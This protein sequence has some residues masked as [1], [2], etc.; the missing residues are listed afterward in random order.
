MD[1][2]CSFF[3]HVR[4]R[5][6]RSMTSFFC[7]M[8]GSGLSDLWSV[9]ISV[10]L[11]CVPFKGKKIRWP[12]LS[13]FRSCPVFR[14]Y[15]LPPP[16][17]CIFWPFLSCFT[18]SC[19]VS[20]RISVRLFCVP[21]KGKK[22]RW[23]SLSFFRSCPAPVFRIYDP[24]PPWTVYSDHSCPVSHHLVLFPFEFR[25]V[26][27]VSRLHV[28]CPVFGFPSRCNL[29]SIPCLARLLSFCPGYVFRPV[30]YFLLNW[31]QKTKFTSLRQYHFICICEGGGGRGQGG[32]WPMGDSGSCSGVLKYAV[33]WYCISTF[34]LHLSQGSGG[35]G[36]GKSGET[37]M[38]WCGEDWGQRD[39]WEKFAQIC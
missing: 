38:E 23:P 6:F 3:V 21:F 35:V 14:I 34:T 18:S 4:L 15:D 19:V 20:V 5:S 16:M 37:R 27:F 28:L 25:F 11:F 26:C 17:N 12:S 7:P 30:F 1:S 13:F 31:Y 39:D 24:P 2:F 22:I 33:T 9:R 36:G 10:R 8:S 29:F 32:P